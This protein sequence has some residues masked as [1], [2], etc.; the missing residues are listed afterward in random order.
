MNEA[1]I[2]QIDNYHLTG[3]ILLANSFVFVV[4][5]YAISLNRTMVRNTHLCRNL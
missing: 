1:I 3:D 4:R 5:E 2:R